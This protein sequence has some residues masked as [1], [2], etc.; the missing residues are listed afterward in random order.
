[1]GEVLYFNSVLPEPTGSEYLD[2]LEVGIIILLA[3]HRQGGNDRAA[4]LALGLSMARSLHPESPGDCDAADYLTIL[5][6]CLAK[7]P[8]LELAK[9]RH[10]SRSRAEMQDLLLGRA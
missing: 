6:K 9:L 10:P 2:R 3:C 1:M 4:Q 5:N 8:E 7:L